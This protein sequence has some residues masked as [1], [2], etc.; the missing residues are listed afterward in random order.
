MHRIAIIQFP[1]INTEYETRREIKRAGMIGEFFRWNEP[2]ERLA[3]YDGDVIGG[4]FSYEDRGRSGIIAAL[5]PI[6]NAIKAEA[7]KGKPLLRR[8][9]RRPE[10]APALLPPPPPPR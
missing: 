5:D 9:C 4:G 8:R 10:P 1:G 3:K 7:E 2:A 6:M